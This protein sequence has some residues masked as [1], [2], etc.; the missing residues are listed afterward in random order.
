[1][2]LEIANFDKKNAFAIGGGILVFAIS[3]YLSYISPTSNSRE[4]INK[5]EVELSQSFADYGKDVGQGLVFLGPLWKDVD[6]ICQ[7]LSQEAR[8][9]VRYDT[10][11]DQK[12]MEI[13]VD[14]NN[15]SNQDWHV[16]SKSMWLL[17]SIT[18]SAVVG[19]FSS[20][21]LIGLAFIVSWTWY[22]VL[23][24]IREL[25]KAIRG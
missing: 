25:S 17:K 24:R 18:T 23:E 4:D 10:K 11:P 14:R 6:R 7:P 12:D 8:V 2:K 5:I 13:W 1:M 15:L 22:F 20:I 3:L 21:L 9:M 19:T 16:E